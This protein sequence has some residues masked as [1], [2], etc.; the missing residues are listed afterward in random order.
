MCDMLP[1]LL[2]T[3]LEKTV[4]CDEKQPK[5]RVSYYRSG[6]QLDYQLS[7]TVQSSKISLGSVNEADGS[8]SIPN[9]IL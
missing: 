1:D 2:K 8:F 6:M 9:I 5:A 7:M 4:S 3:L